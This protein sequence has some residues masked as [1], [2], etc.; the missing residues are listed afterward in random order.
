[1]HKQKPVEVVSKITHNKQFMLLWASQFF[2]QTANHFLNF[3][4]VIIITRIT[5][6]SAALSLL[7]VAIGVPAVLF[8]SFAGLVSERLNKRKTMIVTN[9]LRALLVP[10]FF[11]AETNLTQILILAFV[12]STIMQFFAPAET[13]LIPKLVKKESL[14]MANS[15]FHFTFNIAILGGFLLSSILVKFTAEKNFYII[16]AVAS[17]G[18]IIAMTFNALMK[19]DHVEEKRAATALSWESYKQAVEEIREGFHYIGRNIHIRTYLQHLAII[20]SLS[21]ILLLLTPAFARDVLNMQL[22]D[23][24]ILVLLPTV[25]GVTIAFPFMQKLSHRFSGYSLIQFGFLL[26]GSLMAS[27]FLLPW[28]PYPLICL[29]VIVLLLGISNFFVSVPSQSYLQ[30]HTDPKLHGRIFGTMNMLYNISAALPNVIVGLVIDR[31]GVLPATLLLGSFFCGYG[32][33]SIRLHQ[34]IRSKTSK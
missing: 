15:M 29:L 13:T 23:L 20:S 34:H 1:M 17:L 8:G 11:F 16:Y 31:T 22:E 14:V 24:A 33:W 2:S 26:S 12:I 25:I 5:P 27:F 18:F 19:I 28:L 7:F 32:L 9:L 10:L 6:S 3:A 21:T 4:L 30:E